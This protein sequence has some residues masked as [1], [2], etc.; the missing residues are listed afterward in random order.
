M[1][2]PTALYTVVTTTLI[3]VGKGLNQKIKTT[4]ESEYTT[5]S[6]YSHRQ[7]PILLTRIRSN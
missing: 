6:G 3:L 2:R 1:P 5:H 7:S 4:I